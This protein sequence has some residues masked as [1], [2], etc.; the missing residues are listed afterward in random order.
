MVVVV[1]WSA[2]KRV[3][4]TATPSTPPRLYCQQAGG[5][6][7]TRELSGGARTLS[8]VYVEDARFGGKLRADVDTPSYAKSETLLLN[9][10]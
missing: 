5:Q 7:T 3:G 9:I 8:F 1:E 4:P 2:S 10:S 6:S